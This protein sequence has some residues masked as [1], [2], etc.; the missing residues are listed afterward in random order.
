M[1][2]DLNSKKCIAVITHDCG[3]GGSVGNVA[4]NQIEQLQTTHTVH[5]IS[6]QIPPSSS[7]NIVTHIIQPRQWG[8]LRRFAHV[9]NELSFQRAAH[10]ALSVLSE[11]ATLNA[12]WCHSHG[13]VV[14]AAAAVSGQKEC[15]ILLTAHGDIY[16]RAV[17]T[18]D[19]FLT[20]YFKFC[21]KRA[22]A[23][24]SQIQALS[25]YMQEVIQANTDEPAKVIVIP[26]GVDPSEIGLDANVERRPEFFSSNAEL[27]L[28]FIGNM[29]PIKGV[30]FLL[31]A[32][33]L[34]A[35]DKKITLT[36]I[37]DG[38]ELIELKALTAHLSIA[39]KVSFLG[40]V[41]RANLAEHYLSAD[42]LCVPSESDALPTVV[43]EGFCAG[44]P[45]I[46]SRTGGI[47]AMLGD[48]R[49]FLFETGNAK[50][51]AEILTLILADKSMLATMSLACTAAADTQYSWSVIG[52]RL[53]AL[54]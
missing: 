34:L 51:L 24:S 4:W 22:Y 41:P 3:A 5:V 28:L 10:K 26:N 29:R 46:G 12:V 11:R 37:G 14:F 39:D 16:D 52:Q 7:K 42:L 30:R 32:I 13:S 35:P 31:H 6:M 40:A 2:S 43:L 21:T 45:A 27:S 49:G 8:G 20:A 47:I 53:R 44:L 25:P 50:Q 36:C 1:P 15:Q 38:P 17:G 9:P 18:Y 48:G 19:R 33:A 23:K 54:L